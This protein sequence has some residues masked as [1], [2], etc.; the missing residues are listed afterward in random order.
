[1]RAI[2]IREHGAVATTQPIELAGGGDLKA[3]HP[4]RERVPIGGFDHELEPPHDDGEMNDP[5]V[6]AAEA[7]LQRACDR[8]ARVAIVKCAG[9]AHDA[10]DHVDG[11]ARR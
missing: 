10:R 6:A 2:A 3:L 9:A 7:A 11:L 5:E 4:T 8:A 1:M